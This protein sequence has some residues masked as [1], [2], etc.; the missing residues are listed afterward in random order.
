MALPTTGTVR[1]AWGDTSPPTLV[2]IAAGVAAPANHA[3]AVR[4]TY[5]IVVGVFDNAG[6]AWSHP[7]VA[8]F[9]A[10]PPGPPVITAACS[11][12]TG[13]GA[14]GT[15]VTIPGHGFTGATSVGFAGANATAVVVVND[16]TITCTTPPGAG[17]VAVQVRHP[18]GNADRA[19]AFMFV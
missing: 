16:S 1:I 6:A 19:N 11:P 12:Q 13:P 14:G 17:L 7:R 3:Y 8:T 18:L 15:A 4:G 9:I 5:S 2:A 10:R